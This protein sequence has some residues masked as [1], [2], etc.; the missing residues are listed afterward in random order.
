MLK[1]EEKE[2][3]Q[4]DLAEIK[5][6]VER[7]LKLLGLKAEVEVKDDF[8][9]E[10]VV[11]SIDAKEESG[12]LI[13]SRGKTLSSIQFLLGLMFKNK[14]GGWKRIIVD[15]AKWREKEEERLREL[16][17]QVAQRAKETGLPQHLYNL[18]PAQRRIV[19]LTL[20][21][22]KEVKTE[23]QGEGS[24]RYLIVSPVKS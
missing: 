7:L 20:S 24:E 3:N 10:S 9:N 14:K 4:K 21:E 23:S 2:S 16:S 12:L 13:G 5:S 18:T 6:L 19:H 1:K 17:L 11:V 8:E 22:D 15:V